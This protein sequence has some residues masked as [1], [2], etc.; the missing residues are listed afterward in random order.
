[1]TRALSNQLNRKGAKSAK[2]VELD[3]LGGLRVFAVN[4]LT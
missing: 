4:L 2:E 1:V 3:F